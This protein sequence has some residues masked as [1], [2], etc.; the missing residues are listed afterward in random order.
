MIFIGMRGRKYLHLERLDLAIMSILSG[1][2]S[3]N[4]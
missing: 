4:L 1:F 2:G 3:N